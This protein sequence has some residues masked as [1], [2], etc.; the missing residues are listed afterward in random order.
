MYKIEEIIEAILH[1]IGEQSIK[2]KIMKAFYL[3]EAE[4]Y[5]ETGKRLT[6]AN[7]IHYYY[8]PYSY[9]VVNALETDPNVIRSDEMSY[10][11]KDYEL[12]RL[13]KTPDIDRIDPFTLNL[14]KKQAVLIQRHTL[15]EVLKVAYSDSNFK[16]TKQGEEIKFGSDFTRKKQML[17]ERLVKKF[18]N[19]E[20]TEKELKGLKEEGN[21]ELIQYSRSLLKNS[22]G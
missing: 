22:K 7:F 21:E 8:G 10:W 6:D 1:F 2:T 14:I 20:L 16:Q 12:Y 15:D 9:E 11:G 4:Y 19:R 18:G 13:Q 3:L 5:K 17:K